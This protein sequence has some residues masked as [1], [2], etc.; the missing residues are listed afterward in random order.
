MGSMPSK[1]I[2]GLG[3]SGVSCSPATHSSCAH[4]DEW[5]VLRGNRMLRPI[6]SL[7]VLHLRLVSTLNRQ[8]AGTFKRHALTNGFE[9]LGTFLTGDAAHV[10]TSRFLTGRSLPHLE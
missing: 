5:T 7:F 6:P 1:G 4:E 8:S 2:N 3:C 10:A 9:W